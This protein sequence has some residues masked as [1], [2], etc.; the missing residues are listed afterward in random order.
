M[1]N[2][3]FKFLAFVALGLYVVYSG[4]DYS[5]GVVVVSVT[6]VIFFVVWME[7]RKKHN[8]V[9]HHIALCLPNALSSKRSAFSPSLS[10]CL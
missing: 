7:D 5:I 6:C 10:P 3:Y 8:Q 2:N 9:S 4:F 1:S